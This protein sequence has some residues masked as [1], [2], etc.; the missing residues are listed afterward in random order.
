MRRFCSDGRKRARAITKPG[1][2]G[3]DRAPLHC[4]SIRH[5]PRGHITDRT[6]TV[7]NVGGF[8]GMSFQFSS[9]KVSLGYRADF[10]FDAMDGGIDARKSATLGFYGP[11]ASVSVGFGG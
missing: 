2:T 7:P 3:P 1:T 4:Q 11:F 10:F 5:P 6:V 8:A 9:A